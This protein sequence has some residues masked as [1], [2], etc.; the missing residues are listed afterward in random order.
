MAHITK[1]L[2]LGFG[3]IETSAGA[4]VP[5]FRH[6][7]SLTGDFQRFTEA[8]GQ[9][10]SQVPEEEEDRGQQGA[11]DAIVQV[12]VCQEEIGWRNGS[13]LLVY[14]ADRKRQGDFVA[15]SKA[16]TCQLQKARKSVV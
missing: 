8:I 10:R 9:V 4:K 5:R 2:R 12:S 13:R 16:K 6:V 1:D 3:L 15:G 11:V 7:L 14:S